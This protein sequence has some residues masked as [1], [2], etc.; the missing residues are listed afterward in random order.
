VSCDTGDGRETEV[1]NAGLPVLV[2][3]DVRLHGQIR[4]VQM[5]DSGE[6]HTPFKSP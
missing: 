4:D 2:D 6:S 3:Q 1:G 5:L